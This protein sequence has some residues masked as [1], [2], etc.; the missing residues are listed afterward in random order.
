MV[1]VYRVAVPIVSQVNSGDIYVSHI[2]SDDD[3]W[4]GLSLVNTTSSTKELTV[5][6][7]NGESKVISLDA[8]MHRAVTIS[9]LFEGEPQPEI[10]SAVITNADG[11]VGLELFGSK[12]QNAGYLSGVLLKDKTAT[13]IYFP[14]IASDNNWWTGLVAYNPATECCTLDITPYRADG[15]VLTSPAPIQLAGQGKY[16][17][18]VSNLN[19]PTNTAWLRITASHLITGFELFGTTNNQQMAGYTGIGIAGMESVFVTLEK[20]GW[21]GIAFVNLENNPAAITLTAYAEDGGIVASTSINLAAYAKI[22]DL[23]AN[24]FASQDISQ[25]TYIRSSSNKQVVGFQLNGSSDNM[26]LDALPGM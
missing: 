5:L 25:A 13:E 4:T 9:E 3:W 7:D 22:V 20:E 8:G 19:L 16:I 11:I 26:M 23:P 18:A 24:L 6:F 12:G 14:H 21:T 15:T 10:L 17:G 1:G 2:A